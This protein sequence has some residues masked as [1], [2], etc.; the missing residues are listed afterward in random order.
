MNRNFRQTCFVALL[1]V[2]SGLGCGL[3]PAG[4]DERIGAV[5]QAVY[6]GCATVSYDDAISSNYCSAE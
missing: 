1:G 4:D 2:T 5:S 3:S 6:P